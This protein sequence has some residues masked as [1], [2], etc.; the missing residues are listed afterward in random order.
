MATGADGVLTD[1]AAGASGSGRSAAEDH[2]LR[3]PFATLQIQTQLV[4]QALGTGQ[5]HIALA[6]LKSGIKRTS[7]LVKQLL[8]ASRLD[9]SGSHDPCQLLRMDELTLDAAIELP[10][11]PNS[12][13]LTWEWS[14]WMQE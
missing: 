12:K 4:E 5:E 11:F 3:T 9:S 1:A 6:D 8:M 13:K 10:P 7:H 2:E 14:V